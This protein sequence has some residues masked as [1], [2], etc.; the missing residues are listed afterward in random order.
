MSAME[1]FSVTET[2]FDKI[3]A[4]RQTDDL[5]QEIVTTANMPQYT[6]PI[7]PPVKRVVL[8]HIVPGRGG[9]PLEPLPDLK[10]EQ[11]FLQYKTAIYKSTPY[12]P[13][14]DETTIE[15]SQKDDKVPLGVCKNLD[16]YVKHGVKLVS[17]PDCRTIVDIITTYPELGCLYLKRSQ[18]SS[19]VGY[20]AYCFTVCNFFDVDPEEYFTISPRAFAEFVSGDDPRLISLDQ[21]RTDFW[22]YTKLKEL[23]L[24]SQYYESKFFRTWR[25][26]MRMR[27]WHDVQVRL[28]PILRFWKHELLWKY[29]REMDASCVIGEWSEDGAERR[30]LDEIEKTGARRS[31]FDLNADNLES[32]VTRPKVVSGLEVGDDIGY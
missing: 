13:E 31:I 8:P 9:V 18:S 7:S 15:W 29:R 23:S 19:E 28:F 5:K 6:R 20:N 21:L 10:D 3:L 22:R 11:T 25:A 24:F 12:Q 32:G 27:M 26:K 30:L 4:S 2:E 17:F 1:K 16:E 14:E